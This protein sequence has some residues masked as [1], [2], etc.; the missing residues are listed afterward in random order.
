[1]TKIL[2]VEDE[3]NLRNTVAFILQS[4]GF[5]V[6]SAQT[7]KKALCLV[8]EER[9]E[10]VLLD[11]DLSDIDGFD[12]CQRIRQHSGTPDVLVLL[13]SARNAKEDVVEGFARDADDYLAKPFHPSVLLARIRAL[14]RRKGPVSLDTHRPLRSEEVEVD[15]MSYEV[16]VG[17]QKIPVTKTEFD[18][19]YLLAAQPHRVF[20]RDEIL[21]SLRGQDS[22]IAQR[23]V[24]FQVVGLRRKLGK[25]AR[26]IETVRGVGYKFV[27]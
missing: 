22:A 17:G 7:G 12:V 24:D 21:G 3:E 14:L 27:A 19:L 20:T 11:V 26:V 5:V 15:L 18:I 23:A 4:E 25:A 8:D 10:L 2:L 6:V 1:M 9:P 16:K 13:V